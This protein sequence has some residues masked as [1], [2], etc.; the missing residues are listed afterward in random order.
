[1]IQIAGWL[2][3]LWGRVAFG[4]VLLAGLFVWREADKRNQQQKGADKVISSVAKQTEKTSAKA[5]QGRASARA[6]GSVDRVREW[7]RDCR[8]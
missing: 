1:M 4:G 8:D 7:C 2:G 5:N 6:P 3:T